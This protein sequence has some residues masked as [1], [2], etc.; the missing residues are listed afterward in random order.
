MEEERERE[1]EPM[2]QVWIRNGVPKNLVVGER[3]SFVC[4][5]SRLWHGLSI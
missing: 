5:R 3:K 4:A 1:R 2:R